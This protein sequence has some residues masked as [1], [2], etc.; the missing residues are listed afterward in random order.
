MQYEISVWVERSVLKIEAK[1]EIK[2]VKHYL[3]NKILLLQWD[4]KKGWHD[5]RLDI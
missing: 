4:K 1:V 3:M 5:D 2:Y